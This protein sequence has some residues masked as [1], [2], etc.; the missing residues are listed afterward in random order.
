MTTYKIREQENVKIF[1]FFRER[2]Q[3]YLSKVNEKKKKFGRESNYRGF[4]EKFF[5]I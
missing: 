3:R 4:Y 5:N 2:D 1:F